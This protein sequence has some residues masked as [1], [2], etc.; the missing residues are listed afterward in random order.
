MSK[1]RKHSDRS[2]RPE[3]KAAT[4]AR[5]DQR[6]ERE[7]VATMAERAYLRLIEREAR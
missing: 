5:R 2:R 6:A 4:R 3:A 1:I 7:R